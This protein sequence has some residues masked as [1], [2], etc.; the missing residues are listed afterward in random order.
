MAFNIT[1]ETGEVTVE[2]LMQLR[3]NING[4]SQVESQVE[5]KGVDVGYGELAFQGALRGIEKVGAG[6]QE[7]GRSAFTEVTGVDVLSDW[8][9]NRQEL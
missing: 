7:L 9:N 3:R 4:K 1:P 8:K 2:S 6:V 5:P